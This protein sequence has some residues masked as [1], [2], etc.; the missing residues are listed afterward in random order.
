[1]AN[2]GEG[3]TRRIVRRC[4]EKQILQRLLKPSPDGAETTKNDG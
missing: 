1:M 3:G 4:L 2:A